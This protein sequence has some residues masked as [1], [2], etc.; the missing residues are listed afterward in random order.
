MKQIVV[1]PVNVVT[2]LSPQSSSICK[3]AIHAGVVK[4]DGGFVDVLPLERRKGYTGVLKNDI[5]SE[6]YPPRTVSVF[7]QLVV[8]IY[9]EVL[10]TS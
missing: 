4:T 7:A 1:K 5:Q 6:R 3:S 8:V 10:L 9:K 2:V